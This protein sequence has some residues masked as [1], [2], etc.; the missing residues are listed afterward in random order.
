MHG[1]KKLPKEKAAPVLL[2]SCAPGA[3]GV[4]RPGPGSPVG[5]PPCPLASAASLRA[6]FGLFRPGT[7]M[8]DAAQGVNFKVVAFGGCQNREFKPIPALGHTNT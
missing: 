3:L 6:P 1:Q 8:L 4:S 2:M 7:A 5:T